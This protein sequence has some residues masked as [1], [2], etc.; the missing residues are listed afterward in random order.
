MTR[1]QFKEIMNEIIELEKVEEEITTAFRKLD[2]DFNFISFGRYSNLIIK[3]LEIAMNDKD[4]WIQ[5]WV[6]E[7]DYGTKAK[8]DS[9]QDEDGI[10]IPIKTLDDLYN[11]LK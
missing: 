7:L 1:K 9:V 3:C 8:E 10:N 2:D 5:Y 6:Y 11:I 4:E